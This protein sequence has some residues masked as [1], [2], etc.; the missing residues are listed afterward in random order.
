M[1]KKKSKLPI[2]AGWHINLLQGAML[3]GKISMAK[4]GQG[5]FVKEGKRVC[6]GIPLR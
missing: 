4:C 2:S 1:K 5:I 6:E 3:R